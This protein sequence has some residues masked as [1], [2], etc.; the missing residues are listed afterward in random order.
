[1]NIK[2]IIFLFFVLGPTINYASDTEIKI[3]TN[4]IYDGYGA[5]NVA[6]IKNGEKWIAIIPSK[7]GYIAKKVNVAVKNVQSECASEAKSIS[8][9]PGALLLIKGLPIKD[10]PLTKFAIHFNDSLLTSILNT[11][12]GEGTLMEVEGKKD[13]IKLIRKENLHQITAK[14]GD[15]ESVLTDIEFY[16]FILISDL[17]NDG[18]PDFIFTLSS[19]NFDRPALFLSTVNSD[20]ITYYEA[21]QGPVGGC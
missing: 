14:V 10:G 19:D 11:G 5:D 21:A 16:G 12:A 7:A 6:D 3:L 8:S 4:G 15:K 13:T 2:Y 20:G 9:D 18:Y 1:M 17:N